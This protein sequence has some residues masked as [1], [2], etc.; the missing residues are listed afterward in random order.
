[1]GFF[2]FIF[3]DDIAKAVEI[4]FV[5]PNETLGDKILAW[6]GFE[7]TFA[8]P[9]TRCDSIVN[10]DYGFYWQLFLFNQKIVNNEKANTI[11]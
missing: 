10:Q 11:L 5:K 4:P 3:W 7:I 2:C 1:M 6:A 8:H 9:R